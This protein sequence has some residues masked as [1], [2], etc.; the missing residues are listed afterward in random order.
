VRKSLPKEVTDVKTAI[1]GSKLTI[2]PIRWAHKVDVLGIVLPF[3]SLLLFAASIFL[4]PVRRTAVQRAAIAVAVAA[5]VG[6]IVLIVGRSYA[7]AQIADPLFRDA[8]EAAWDAVLGD[9]FV[10]VVAIGV[11][12]LIFAAAARF[13]DGEVDPLQP[14]HRF[15]EIARAHPSR[16]LLG[17]LRGIGIALVGLILITEPTFSLQLIAIAAGAWLIYVAIVEVLAI[18]APVVP[19][20]EEGE[21]ARR[22]Q[23]MRLAAAGAVVAGAIAIVLVVGGEKRSQA[24]PP[25]APEA[26]NGYP[27]LCSKRIDQ[28]TI[29]ATHNSM[30]AAAEGGWFLPNQR[31]GIVRQLDD[32]IRGL[33]ID[34][35]Y[36]I[37]RG[38]G[39]SREFGG[40]VTDLAR[41][42]KTRQE[43]VKELGEDTVKRAE[44]LIGRLAFG[45]EPHGDAKPYLCHVLC[46]LGATKLD[47]ALSKIADWMRTHPDEFLTIVVEDVVS[48]EETAQAFQRAG[49]VRY[50]YTPTPGEVPPTLGKMIERDKRLLVFAE[51]DSGG[52]KFPWYLSAFDWIQETPYTF[53]TVDDITGPRS[54]RENRGDPDNPL[55]QIN[56]WIE[57]V[58]RDPELQGKINALD[59]LKERAEVCARVRG[60]EP[61]VIAVDYYN[62]GD[63]VGVAKALNGIPADEEP[64]VR[65]I[66]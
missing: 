60:M 40:V 48:P 34:T 6:L 35:H 1:L 32:G 9:L 7:M 8:A 14:F 16:P 41:E 64:E 52:G 57:R 28:V 24:R 27:Q 13:D 5:V 49:L 56:N 23:P 47:T 63:V 38:S 50:A 21:V 10:W 30:S 53:K 26:C 42:N 20:G 12:S 59:V 2:T 19:A 66:R 45:E 17:V 43:V 44:D 55:F 15:A 33:L 62:E 61:N 4:A 22:V 3:V 51:R 31:Y 11:L 65:T 58:P 25:G 39:T 54:C 18:I 29:P 36:G 46:E 37:A